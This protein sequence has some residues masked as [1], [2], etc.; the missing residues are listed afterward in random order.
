MDRAIDSAAAEQRIVRCID[1]RVDG[2]GR[3]VDLPGLL[4]FFPFVR[5]AAFL[6]PGLIEGVDEEYYVFRLGVW[7]TFFGPIWAD[8]GW[9]GLPFMFVFGVIA[10]GLARRARLGQLHVLPLHLYMSVVIVFMPVVN[11][12]TNALG[13]FTVVSF[14]LFASA[15]RDRPFAAAPAQRAPA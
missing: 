13:W 3:D 2:Q 5:V 12:L 7:Q 1:D 15:V 14:I 6:Y 4:T 10:A 9:L 11:L 8:F